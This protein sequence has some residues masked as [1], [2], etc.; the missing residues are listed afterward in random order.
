MSKLLGEWLA[1]ARPARD[2]ERPPP[3]QGPAPGVWVLRVE[4]LFGDA[5]PGRAEKGSVHG[6]IT[7]IRAGAP[8][9]VF[10]DRTVSPSY[11]RDIARATRT[12]LDGSVPP[13]LYHCVN[14]GCASWGEVA[15]EISRLLRL[16]LRVE[17]MTL[18]AANLKAPRPRYC[19]LSNAKLAAAGVTMP[20]WQDALARHLSAISR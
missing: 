15:E 20:S 17:K 7:R 4:S 1:L 16:P 5:A 14:S 9:P 18:E 11:T 10:V 3:A 2:A 8:V 12:V 19:A 6:I 13:G